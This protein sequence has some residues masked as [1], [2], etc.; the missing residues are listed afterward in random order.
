MCDRDYDC[1]PKKNKWYSKL[2][3]CGVGTSSSDNPLG[4]NFYGERSLSTSL[5]GAKTSLNRSAHGGSR[6]ILH[7]EE[8]RTLKSLLDQSESEN[9]ILQQDNMSLLQENRRLKE[10]IAKLKKTQ[11]QVMKKPENSKRETQQK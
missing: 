7:K 3:K 6:S 10:E 11:D 4:L 1:Y 5:H 9:S 2:Q 8:I